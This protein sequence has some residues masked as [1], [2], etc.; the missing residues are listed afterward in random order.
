MLVTFS[1]RVME[2]KLVQPEK[3]QFLIAVTE[4]GIVSS[5]TRFPFKYKFLA[6]ESGLAVEFSISILHHASRLL[7]CTAVRLLQPSKA[8]SP[9]LVTPSGMVMEVKLLQL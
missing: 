1:G 2:A 3:A 9:M 8:Q 4:L 7:I 6:K 5:V